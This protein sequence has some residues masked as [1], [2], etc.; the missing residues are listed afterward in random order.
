MNTHAIALKLQHHLGL[1]LIVAAAVLFLGIIV[2]VILRKR[3][4]KLNQLNNRERW[5]ELQKLCASK[6]TWPDAVLAADDMLDET[7][8]RLKYK[9]KTMGERLV[10]AQRDLS[11]NETVWFGH[12][13]RNK[14]VHEE[15]KLTRKNEVKEALLGYWQA[16]KDLGALKNDK[17]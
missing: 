15:Y 5:L 6:T 10:S 4:R 8:K 12:K 16:L 1:V 14:I 11:S 7:L 3:P 17:R 2:I 9:G 13:L